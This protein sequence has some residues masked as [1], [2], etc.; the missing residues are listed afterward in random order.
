MV[1]V[2]SDEVSVLVAGT[3]CCS[4]IEA[5]EEIR[6]IG[7][8]SRVDGGLATWCATQDGMV[9]FTDGPHASGH[10][11]AHPAVALT[12]RRRVP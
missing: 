7:R 8:G 5:C 10:G 2:L 1:G 4:A 12:T 3:V 11:G 9:T 6:E